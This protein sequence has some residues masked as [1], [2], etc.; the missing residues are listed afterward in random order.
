MR[1]T[2]KSGKFTSSRT[3]CTYKEIIVIPTECVTPTLHN[4]EVICKIYLL[5]HFKC[6][7]NVLELE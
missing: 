6:V 4:L 1:I 5:A 7:M 2:V 3:T